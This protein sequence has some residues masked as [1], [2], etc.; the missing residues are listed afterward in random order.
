MCAMAPNVM[1]MT[2]LFFESAVLE[3]NQ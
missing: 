2:C 1:L 3:S